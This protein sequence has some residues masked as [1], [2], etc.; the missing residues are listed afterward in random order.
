M[1]YEEV[2]NL[3]LRRGFYFPTSEIYPNSPGGFWEFGPIGER[4]RQ[5]VLAMWRKEL[6]RKEEFFEISGSLILSENVFMASGHLESFNDPIVQCKKCHSL[7][8][9]DKLIEEKTGEN[10][11]E[12]LSEKELN[13]KIRLSG[14]ICSKCKSNEFGECRKF[15]MMIGTNIGATGENKCYLRPETCQNIFLDFQRVYKISRKNLPIGIAQAGPAFRNEIA[16]RNTLL[17]ER[18]LGQME[19]EIFFNPNKINEVE[20]WEEVK[21][22]E[23]NLLQVGKKEI[24]KVSCEKA[25]NEK[26]VSGRLVAYYL[27][28]VQQ[29]YEKYGFKNENMRF[30]GLEK[31]ERAFYAKETWD[32][33]VKTSLGW[34]ELIANNY[35]GDHDLKGHSKGSK[36]DLSVNEDGEKYLPHVFEIS[37]GIDRTV[38][39]VIENSYR[40]E[41][42]NNEERVYLSLPKK[43]APYSVAIFPLVKKDGIAEKAREIWKELNNKNLEVLYDEKG[44]IGRRY[45]RVDEIGVSFAITIDYQTLEDDTVTLRERDSTIQHRI[46]TYDIISKIG[47]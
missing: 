29:L 11:P 21:D 45:A 8:R 3:A 35:R 33:E 14:A 26:I 10:V 27:A 19:V 32:F 18:E 4:I 38:Y 44:S 39:A 17:R 9:A 5:N 6:V 7:F 20:N 12:S 24:E 42:K 22:Y 13:E 46:K 15:N 41:M 47:E 2:T 37:A 28:R 25:V 43:I 1:S 23:L 40:K 36:T 16:P 31:E 30:R 34:V